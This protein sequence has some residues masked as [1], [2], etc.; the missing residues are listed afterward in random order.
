MQGRIEVLVP[1]RSIGFIRGQ[2]TQHIYFSA[3]SLLEAEF[4]P[5][6]IGQKVAFELKWGDKGP[7]ADN[8]RP[9]HEHQLP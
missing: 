5:L 4:A 1:P 6:K 8:V 7:E 2:I 3:S 9:L